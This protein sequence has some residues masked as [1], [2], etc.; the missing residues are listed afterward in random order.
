MASACGLNPV[1]CEAADALILA[2]WEPLNPLPA[3]H[4][5]RL[6]LV[7]LRFSDVRHKRIFTTVRS[8]ELRG[9]MSQFCC[10][11]LL[12]ACSTVLW[13]DRCRRRSECSS[14]LGLA[15]ATQHHRQWKALALPRP[16]RRST[17]LKQAK[18]Q[19]PDVCPCCGEHC[20]TMEASENGILISQ[21]NAVV[22]SLQR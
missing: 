9:S 17:I 3:L 10:D 22:T 13:Q 16:V 4:I 14:V 15:A 11:P 5:L 18:R 8:H 20:V 21:H 12:C 19:F 7:C 1:R 2:P 6:A